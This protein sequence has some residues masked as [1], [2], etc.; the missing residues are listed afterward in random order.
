MSIYKKING[1]DVKLADNGITNH[2]DL[3]GRNSYGAHNIPAIRGLPEK[4]T[5]LKTKIEEN[6]ESISK[7][8]DD[9]SA[10]TRAIAANTEKISEVETK[11][12]GIDLVPAEN[13][14]VVF[15]N[16]NGEK[17]SL[18]S[19]YLPDDNTIELQEFDIQYVE[20]EL[21]EDT[22]VI[23]TYYILDDGDYV[24]AHTYDS[25][26]TYY[27]RTYTEKLVAVSL[28]TNNGTISGQEI[29][30]DLTTMKS[31]VNGQG[32]YLDSANLGELTSDSSDP[33]YE[34][35]QLT[36]VNYAIQD[37]GDG[38]YKPKG[39]ITEEEFNSYKYLYT[40]DDVTET[41]TRA[42]TYDSQAYYFRL[43]IW[44]KTRVV[45]LY[46]D[47]HNPNECTW[48]WDLHSETWSNL[49]HIS[50]IS[51]ANNSGLH[52]LV[53]GSNEDW[54][55]SITAD[56]TIA[57]NGLPELASTVN[58]DHTKL[59]NLV[60]DSYDNSE[61]HTYSTKYS[62]QHFAPLS[63]VSRLYLNKV[64]ATQ[65]SL[66]DEP[67]EQTASYLSITSN[68]DSFNW[69]SPAFTITRT[70]R[71]VTT[72]NEETSFTLTLNFVAQQDC[73]ISFGAKVKV[74]TDGGNTWTYVSS[75][76]PFGENDYRTNVLSSTQFIVYTDLLN[77]NTSYEIGDLI[78]IEVFLK[79]EDTTSLTNNIACGYN[80]SGIT[81]YSYLQFN[82]SNVNINTN[83]IEDG[84]VT[85]PKLSNSLQT[86]ID[87]IGTN[88]S[89]IQTNAGNISSLQT[90]VNNL[91]TSK[92]NALTPT[93]L[94]AVNSGIDSAK[95]AQ[96][97]TN[98]STINQINRWAGRYDRGLVLLWEDNGVTYIWNQDPQEVQVQSEPNAQGG[99]SYTIT[100]L[101][102][103][104]TPNE[105]GGISVEI[106][107]DAEIE[108]GEG[109]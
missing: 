60:K 73:N 100:T 67:P 58:A 83:Q 106:G 25:S 86:A 78:Q 85:K 109:E 13:G 74:S 55:G 24:L 90:S 66:V 79:G 36:L 81:T 8:S 1:H 98:T 52:G 59:T 87:Q 18:Q 82:Y 20:T 95:V 77:V 65:A 72:L 48:V 97:A 7:N 103:I 39:Q 71:A 45:N 14:K 105:Y 28:Q 2:N 44:D 15:T 70:L 69:N 56:G 75:E 50:I 61:E 9:I 68:N 101:N 62:N 89:N 17:T 22:F 33:S 16:Y 107:D 3:G 35:A 63:F 57:V 51:D 46:T 30:E 12:S 19:G 29:S 76:Q 23:D 43:N 42:L 32:G 96:I 27:E 64:G 4:L 104:T 10:N 93:Q 5:F 47:Q 6:T 108:L 80:V 99:M 26:E 94:G 21:T 31:I 41:Y 37:I 49:G 34:E 11:A 91:Q 92:Q 54:E 84:A 88:T 53:T 102:Y 38:V 40:Y